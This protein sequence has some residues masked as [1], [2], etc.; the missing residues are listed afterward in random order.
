VG[1]ISLVLNKNRAYFCDKGLDKIPA[2][3]YLT[4]NTCDSFS[5]PILVWT[6]FYDVFSSALEHG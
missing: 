6:F 3:F 2:I 4:G 1:C 5:V